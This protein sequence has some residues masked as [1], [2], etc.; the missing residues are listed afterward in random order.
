MTLEAQIQKLAP[1]T[2]INFFQFALDETT[3]YR[4]YAGYDVTQPAGIL[5]WNSHT[6]QPVPFETSG[7]EWDGTG[8]LIEPEISIGDKDNM[9]LQWIFSTGDIRGKAIVRYKTLAELLDDNVSLPAELW[10]VNSYEADGVMFKV[11]LAMP[12][13]Q[14]NVKLPRRIM[15]H[16]DFPALSRTRV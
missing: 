4:C 11:K 8:K 7:F 3:M 12:F 5:T 2:I 16:T 13:A 1:G 14:R 6:W 9:L 10:L 15:Y